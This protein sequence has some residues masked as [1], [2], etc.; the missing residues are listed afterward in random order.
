MKKVFAV[1]LVAMMLF[2]FTAC[3][4]KIGA[5]EYAD[6]EAVLSI[7]DAI[8]KDQVVSDVVKAADGDK[9]DGLTVKYAFAD[10]KAGKINVTVTAENYSSGFHDGDNVTVESGELLVTV[11]GAYDPNAEGGPKY[12]ISGYSAMAIQEATVKVG[13]TSYVVTGSIGKTNASGTIQLVSGKFKP[14]NI[15]M[16]IPA[17]GA[18]DITLDGKPIDYEYICANAETVYNPGQ[19]VSVTVS[20]N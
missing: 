7:I 12:T 9:V 19:E 6:N 18:V 20:N 14:E 2:A 1:L 13:E 10:K 15:K 16:T 17:T 11:Y 3:D 4:E 8:D 5:P